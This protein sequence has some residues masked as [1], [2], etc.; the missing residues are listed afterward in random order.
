MGIN[1]ADTEGD[2]M[3]DW[4]NADRAP[5]LDE[6]Y[7]PTHSRLLGPDG[8]PLPYKEFKFGFQVSPKSRQSVQ[9]SVSKHR[10]ALRRLADR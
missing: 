6:I 9:T 10:K 5:D 8:H 2:L 4:D 7:R 3:P 1:D